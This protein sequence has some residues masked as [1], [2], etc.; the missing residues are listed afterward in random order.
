MA[1]QIPNFKP[2]FA[3]ADADLSAKQFFLVK[4]VAGPAVDLAGDGEAVYAVVQNK[5]TSGEEAEIMRQGISKCVAG[6]AVVAGVKVA[7]DAAGKVIT[8]VSGKHPVGIALTAAGS[9]GDII[10]VDILPSLVPLA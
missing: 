6:A 9:D 1:F 8:A 5:P 10:S 4:A 2:G 3:T 7:S